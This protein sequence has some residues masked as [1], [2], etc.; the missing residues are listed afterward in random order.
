[1]PVWCLVFC[2]FFLIP[3]P[4]TGLADH[5]PETSSKPLFEL[6][7]DEGP[8]YDIIWDLEACHD[9]HL[10]I[11][12]RKEEAARAE[13]DRIL[14]EYWKKVE[15]LLQEGPKKKSAQD[16]DARARLKRDIQ[17]LA[18]EYNLEAIYPGS[19]E[20]RSRR[21]RH[22]LMLARFRLNAAREL[23]EA[24]R[25]VL[26]KRNA[27]EYFPESRPEEWDQ[28][29][30]EINAFQCPETAERPPLQT[31]VRI[32]ARS[33]KF[34]V[35]KTF[36]IDRN[37]LGPND[38]QELEII[39]RV[40][41]LPRANLVRLLKEVSAQPAKEIEIQEAI[42]KESGDNKAATPDPSGPRDSTGGALDLAGAVS[43]GDIEV[44]LRV[45]DNF[46]SVD[47]WL[48]NKSGKEQAI[49][50][51]GAVLGTGDEGVQRLASSG[52][53]TEQPPPGPTLESPERTI[54][55]LREEAARRLAEAVKRVRDGDHSEEALRELL[56]A[57]AAARSIGEL[58]E[59][60]EGAM[61]VFRDGLWD[62]TVKSYDFYKANPNDEAN[63]EKLLMYLETVRQVDPPE[64]KQEEFD[65]MRDEVLGFPAAKPFP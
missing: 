16:R 24:Y 32:P 8:L 20:E 38:G 4:I 48:E 31:I 10:A 59:S 40:S 6:L 3:W 26:V 53:D 18:S 51:S 22:H 65:R 9:K 43:S 5:T 13:R 36:C 46:S 12:T 28:W 34:L 42:W 7:Y 30:A 64:G 60:L 41:S 27:E 58:D 62:A 37:K 44:D 52:A 21:C 49:D 25:D 63:R 61:Q 23:N 1:M 29:E 33:R 35:L 45:R 57:M 11:L 55:K 15:K 14:E 50:I 39:G 47:L 54:E 19:P 56:E 17:L 2:F